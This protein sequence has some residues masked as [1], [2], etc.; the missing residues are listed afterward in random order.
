MEEQI[1]HLKNK[2]CD[3]TRENKVL[4]NQLFSSLKFEEQNKKLKDEIESLRQENQEL[5]VSTN[6]LVMRLQKLVFDEIT[7]ALDNASI[8]NN[9]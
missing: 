6:C 9:L 5:S 3:L 2:L 7:D 8:E 1:V 4:K